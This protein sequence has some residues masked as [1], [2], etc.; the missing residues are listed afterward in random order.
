ML[1]ISC[2]VILLY[3]VSTPHCQLPLSN[4]LVIAKLSCN[5]NDNLETLEYSLHT[6]LDLSGAPSQPM[7]TASSEFITSGQEVTLTCTSVVSGQ[8]VIATHDT[9]VSEQGCRPTL[10]PWWSRGDR[11]CPF[12]G[13]H[14]VCH[15]HALFNHIMPFLTINKPTP[16]THVPFSS[17]FGATVFLS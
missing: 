2:S 12:L 11:M 13:P 1:Y 5:C 4:F 7:V 6:V 8:W 15:S 10:P 9:Q 3:S 14:L 17:L 16:A